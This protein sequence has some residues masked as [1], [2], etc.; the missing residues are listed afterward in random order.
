ME[1]KTTEIRTST[2][3]GKADMVTRYARGINF[4]TTPGHGGFHVTARMN[5]AIPDYFKA[6]S[7]RWSWSQGL[8]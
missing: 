8:V 3:W 4:Y 1:R 6:A 7:I 2:P 5:A